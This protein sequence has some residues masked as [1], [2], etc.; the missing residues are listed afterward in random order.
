M[1]MTSP[2]PDPVA[3]ARAFL[4]P[5]PASRTA[6]LDFLPGARRRWLP[7]P[8]GRLAAAQAGSG[9]LVLLVHGWEGRASDLATIAQR[10]L[11]QGFGVLSIELP[12]HGDSDGDS[13]SIPAAARALAAA[14]AGQALH[15][16]VAHS[17][18][19]AVTVEALAKGLEAGRVALLAVPA[20]YADYARGFARQA[21][22]DGAGSDAMLAALAAAGVEVASVSL[23]ARAPAM[24][25]SALFVHSQDD[26][27][28]PLCDAELS[29]SAWPGARL[30][31][32]DGLGHRRLLQDAAVVD[33]VAA[34]LA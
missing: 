21:G 31:R 4:R 22:L 18:G 8:E 7:T 33:A 16:I 13:T 34:F 5:N 14:L 24:T 9:P 19:C 25:A 1:N 12:A 6:T 23:P 11:D 20:R 15:G 29:S 32:V 17:V 3:V 30:M 10:L 27:V 26:R 2:A 28:V